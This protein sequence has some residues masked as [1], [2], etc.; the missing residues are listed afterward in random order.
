M[1]YQFKFGLSNVIMIFKQDRQAK[2]DCHQEF[3]NRTAQA[4]EI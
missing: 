1:V 2:L 4:F 3:Q